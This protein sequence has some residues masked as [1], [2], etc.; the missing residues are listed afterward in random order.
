[1]SPDSPSPAVCK[2][3]IGEGLVLLDRFSNCLWAY[4]DSAREVWEQVERG[5]SSDDIAADL[6]QRYNIPSD[7]ARADV[8]AIL[9]QWRSH[10]LVGANGDRASP[11]QPATTAAT[12][13]SRQP[14]PSWGA[15]FTV[16]IRGKIFALAIE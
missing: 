15:S 6:A 7:V 9:G 16:R 13:W 14:E 12:D 8:S 1:M 3:P 11:I 4:N 2:L 5:G 10:G